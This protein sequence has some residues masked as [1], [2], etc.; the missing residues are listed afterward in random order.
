MSIPRY[1]TLL[2]M[3]L[4]LGG[5]NNRP[6]GPPPAAGTTAT[7]QQG[8]RPE[9]PSHELN[10][11]VPR[12]QN[13][14]FL[15]PQIPLS[16]PISNI[17]EF[18]DCQRLVLE[19]GKYGPL[20]AIF[21]SSRLPIISDATATQAVA[22]ATIYSYDGDYPLLGIRQ[23]FSCLYFLRGGAGGP[24]YRAFMVKSGNEKCDPAITALPTDSRELRV[25]M[26][27]PGSADEDYPP[28]AR[29]DWNGAFQY[30][31]IKCGAAWCSVGPLNSGWAAQDPRPA[32]PGTAAPAAMRFSVKGWHDHQL[33]APSTG[34]DPWDAPTHALG[35]VVPVSDLGELTDASFGHDWAPVA[36]VFIDQPVDG[37]EGKY[38]FSQTEPTGQGNLVSLCSGSSGACPNLPENIADT[39]SCR[40]ANETIIKESATGAIVSL[41]YARVRAARGGAETYHCVV[42]RDHTNDYPGG[43]IPGTARWR[44][45][46]DDDGI[47]VRCVFGC[48]QL[49]GEL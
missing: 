47:W 33:L 27:T 10:I 1:G 42:R 43:R 19:N 15:L 6:P 39:K 31:G 11:T 38:G 13:P 21:A 46:A 14:A 48:C 26:T 20:V 22:L 7:G 36:N 29:W 32:P 28:V 44:W 8:G 5:C 34:H 2:A 3:L 9:C 23:G 12:D 40:V 16:D 4:G 37:Y 17:P 18:H 41:W 45:L 25:I 24:A 49:Y 30:I 35:T